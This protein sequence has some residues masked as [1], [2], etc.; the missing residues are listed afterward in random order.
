MFNKNV[1]GMIGRVERTQDVDERHPVRRAASC[2]WL[3]DE[4]FGSFK[5]QA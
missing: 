1:V 2:N 5:C 4:P 3:S